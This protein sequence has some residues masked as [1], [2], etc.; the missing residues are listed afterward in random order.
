[1]NGLVDVGLFDQITDDIIYE[2]V[3]DL[4]TNHKPRDDQHLGYIN[5]SKT[6]INISCADNDLTIKQ[7]LTSLSSNTQASSTGFVCWQTSSFL[8]D[9]ILTDPKCPFYK[10]FAEKQD[11]SIL[12]MGAGVSGVAVSLLGPRVKNYVASDQKHILKLLKE[13]FS[14]NVPTNKFSSETISTDNSNKAHPKIDIIE[15]D[16][17]H[18]VQGL[19]NYNNVNDR[20]PDML[21]ACDTIYNEFL[22]QPFLDACQQSMNNT[23]GL[24]I[25]IQLRDQSVIELF[26]EQTLESG[27]QLH[28]IPPESLSEDL[29]LGFV[30]YYIVR[31]VHPI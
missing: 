16:W 30:V 26:L 31:P 8:V 3:Y 24:L 29:L 20:V 4:Y 18:P 5:K 1:M 27:L 28:Y 10:S 23:N 2:H 11:L 25:G 15:Y 21:I 7:S 22:I 19:S 6:T 13:N 17:E 14:N 12:E 9:W